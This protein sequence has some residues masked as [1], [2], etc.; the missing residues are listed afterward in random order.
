MW[1][2][3]FVRLLL[4]GDAFTAIFIQPLL[5]YSC[6]FFILQF[7]LRT[8]SSSHLT[9]NF[10]IPSRGGS[11]RLFKAFSVSARLV[12]KEGVKE[13]KNIL[14]L[15]FL[16]QVH[17]SCSCQLFRAWTFLWFFFP[18][19]FSDGHNYLC[20]KFIFLLPITTDLLF[21]L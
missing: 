13:E 17:A 19:L 5:F 9:T 20:R 14:F 16:T 1:T 10:F 15:L 3:V 4:P 18:N 2:C 21:F 11:N 8:S 7:R 6:S 12:R